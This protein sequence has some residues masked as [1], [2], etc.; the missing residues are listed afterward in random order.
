MLVASLFVCDKEVT[1]GKVLGIQELEPNDG[2]QAEEFEKVIDEVSRLPFPAGLR[3]S[4]LKGVRGPRNGKYLLTWEYESVERFE[5]LFPS[6]GG[7]GQEFQDWLAVHGTTVEQLTA[8]STAPPWSD[9]TEI[10]P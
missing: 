7:F 8:L 4:F 6:G 10:A 3:L 2:V 9:Y 5:Q 1:V